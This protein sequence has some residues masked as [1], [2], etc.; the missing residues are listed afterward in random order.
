M[1]HQNTGMTTHRNL[2][3]KKILEKLNNPNRIG[4]MKSLK[5]ILYGN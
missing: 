4:E 1:K 5:E 2:E 3:I